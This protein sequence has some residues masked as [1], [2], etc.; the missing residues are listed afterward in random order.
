MSISNKIVDNEIYSILEIKKGR[1]NLNIDLIS[2]NNGNLLQ[3]VSNEK[4]SEK[5]LTEDLNNRIKKN[6]ANVKMTAFQHK[7]IEFL[8]N[9]EKDII[10]ISN[11]S[12]LKNID[13]YEEFY[14]NTASIDKYNRQ[15]LDLGITRF[16]I[17]K[18]EKNN[19][20]TN[21]IQPLS[22]QITIKKMVIK[23]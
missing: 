19:I 2:E 21:I 18:D 11:I 22:F 7:V 1:L 6:I 13:F 14:K 10:D 9:Q 8:T 20:I 16:L 15:F 4:Y 17:G 23:I 3:Y 5:F 12:F